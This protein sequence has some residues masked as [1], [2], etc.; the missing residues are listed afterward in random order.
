MLSLLIHE[1]GMSFHVFKFSFLS[2]V[3]PPSMYKSFTSLV[4]FI[5]KD[6]I[7]LAAIISGLAC[8]IS[9]SDYSLLV[10]RNTAGCFVLILYPAAMARRCR[11]AN[12]TA[13]T[14]GIQPVFGRQGLPWLLEAAQ[15]MWVAFLTAPH[16]RAVVTTE[17]MTEIRQHFLYFAGW[18]GPL[19]AASVQRV[20][21]QSWVA[22]IE[23]SRERATPEVLSD[24]TPLPHLLRFRA[25]SESE[26]PLVVFFSWRS[27]RL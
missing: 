25:S 20:W 22:A 2:C 8:L 18:A 23:L 19:E 14:I 24:S 26:C 27:L 1:R 13:S 10:C 6:L 3:L 15:E 4:R 9:C 16:H 17:L 11:S 5:P 21:P 12:G 7:L